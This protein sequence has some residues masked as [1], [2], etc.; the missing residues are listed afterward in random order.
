M[1]DNRLLCFG[2]TAPIFDFGDELSD[3]CNIQGI[4]RFADDT[5]I[6]PDKVVRE[7]VLE[8]GFRQLHLALAIHARN[9]ADFGRGVGLLPDVGTGSFNRC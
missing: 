1:G 8:N 4:Q 2:L 3:V 9:F 5:L 7:I 6:T